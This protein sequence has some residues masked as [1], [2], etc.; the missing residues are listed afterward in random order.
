MNY[1]E[2]VDANETV[3]ARQGRM[4]FGTLRKKLVG[5]KY[6]Y[7]LVIKS[8][9]IG[10]MGFFNALK[11]GLAECDGIKAKQQMHCRLLD[12]EGGLELELETGNYMTMEQMMD[13]NLAIVAKDKFVDNFVEGL[14]DIMEE[15][16]GKNIF[17]GSFAPNNVLIRKGDE[18]PMLL[19]HASSFDRTLQLNRLLS[20]GEDF[21]APEVLAGD[22]LSVSSD[23][24][25]LGKFIEWLHMHSKLPYE[26]KK[27]VSK[28]TR[29]EPDARYPSVAAMRAELKELR[30]KK[31]SL[32][33]FVVALGIVFACVGLYFELMPQTA[34]IEFVEGVPEEQEED[35]LDD[36][37]FDPENTDLW[38]DADSTDV[39]TDSVVANGK[40]TMDA[41]MKKAED[42]FRKQ[43]IKEADKILSKVYNNDVMNSN[44][45]SFMAGSNVMREELEK[46]QAELA[47]RS[48]ISS[49]RAGAIAL[50]VITMLMDEKQKNLP[51]YG[52]QKEAKEE[53]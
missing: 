43:F 1:E 34:D 18:L 19:L 20:D 35:F 17:H 49:E 37:S 6:H 52:Y 15:M 44:E 38:D 7:V 21:V 27:V 10:Q 25:S 24:Y 22:E 45:K 36:A 26:Y 46:T 9:L 5:N 47:A 8:D 13:A 4:P 16:H 40:A 14:M 50:Q 31:R 39:S 48:G 42:I 51:K 28:A 2:I 32:I 11:D 33:S 53:E 3:N 30:N 41:Y 29:E 23:V 12:A